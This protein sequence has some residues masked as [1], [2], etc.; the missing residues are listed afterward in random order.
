MEQLILAIYKPLL[1]LAVL[2][3][4]KRGTSRKSKAKTQHSEQ[5]K[6]LEK[7]RKLLMDGQISEETYLELKEE[8]TRN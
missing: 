7:I 4:N 5:T 2:K 6:E 1:Y 8:I 3:N